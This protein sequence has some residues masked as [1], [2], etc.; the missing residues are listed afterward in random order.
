M[1]QISS[2]TFQLCE[3]GAV[4]LDGTC[5]A[6]ALSGRF[7]PFSRPATFTLATRRSS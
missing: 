1:D 2:I 7:R 6:A 3:I 4:T 5:T